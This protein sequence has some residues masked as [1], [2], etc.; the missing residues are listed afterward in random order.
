M[1]RLSFDPAERR[2]N[3][4]KAIFASENRQIFVLMRVM[5]RGV[6]LAKCRAAGACGAAGVYLTRKLIGGERH[7]HQVCLPGIHT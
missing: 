7:A 1:C 3:A 6:S 5:S 4:V 2:P